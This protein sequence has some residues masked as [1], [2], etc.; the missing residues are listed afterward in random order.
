MRA[1]LTMATTALWGSGESRYGN[2]KRI[3]YLE[4]L[5]LFWSIF[6]L[7]SFPNFSLITWFIGKTTGM[8]DLI[9]FIFCGKLKLR[10]AEKWKTGSDFIKVETYLR[11]YIP[12]CTQQ[13]SLHTLQVYMRS[14]VRFTGSLT[15]ASADLWEAKRSFGEIPTQK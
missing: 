12:S 4:V 6:F 2:N 15:A 10:T 9:L 8:E 1:W 11:K 14:K 3:I 5:L 7:A 13:T